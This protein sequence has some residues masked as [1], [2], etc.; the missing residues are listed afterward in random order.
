M[1]GKYREVL[2]DLTFEEEDSDFRLILE[3]KGWYEVVKTAVE[4]QIPQ[5]AV[6]SGTE[7]LCPCCNT[8][9]GETFDNGQIAFLVNHCDRCGQAIKEE[10]ER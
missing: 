8:L 5:K 7:F 10:W 6:K 4:K 9:V 3:E 1:R 2:D